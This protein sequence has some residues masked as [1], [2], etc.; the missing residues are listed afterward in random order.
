MLHKYITLMIF[1]NIKLND[2]ENSMLNPF[3]D[4]AMKKSLYRIK[5]IQEIYQVSRG[6]INNR[7]EDGTFTRIKPHGSRLVY[8]S[9]D[10]V[11]RYFKGEKPIKRIEDIKTSPKK[12]IRKKRNKQSRKI[13]ILTLKQKKK[14]TQES[15]TKNILD[16]S[17][18]SKLYPN[19]TGQKRDIKKLF[20]I[21]NSK[22]KK[23]ECK[24]KK[25]Y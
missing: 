6:T 25:S 3:R 17:S 7:L 22:D 11:D 12:R 1:N 21:V 19:Y 24:R 15:N 23:T 5:D 14:T 18:T 16:M 13:D 20:T 2:K 4:I 10:E 9:C 8:I